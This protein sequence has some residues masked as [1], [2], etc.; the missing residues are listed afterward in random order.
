M[1]L[2]KSIKLNKNLVIGKALSTLIVKTKSNLSHSLSLPVQRKE[3]SSKF[4]EKESKQIFTFN[5][6]KIASDDNKY[7]PSGLK[8]KHENTGSNIL[9]SINLNNLNNLNNSNKNSNSQM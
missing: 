7:L 4:N 1:D 9:P 8:K 2:S 5:L 3:S 6:N